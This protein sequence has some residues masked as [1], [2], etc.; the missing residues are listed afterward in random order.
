[1]GGKHEPRYL[2]C[3]GR[4]EVHANARS[5]CFVIRHSCFVIPLVTPTSPPAPLRLSSLDAYRGLVILT[6]TYVNYISGMKGIPAWAQHMPGDARDGYTFVDLVFPG[7]LFIVGVAIPLALHRRMSEGKSLWPLVCRILLRSASLIFVGVITV[8]GSA[9]NAEATGMSRALWFFLAMVCVMAVWNIYPANPSPRRKKLFFALRIVAGLELAILLFIFRGKNSDGQIVW[10][11]HSWWGILGLIGWAYLVA[12]FAYL[13][14]RGNSTGL[15]AVLGFL[16]ALYIGD[17]HGALDWL[18]PVHDFIGV[19]QV[20]GST[21]SSV[22]MGT[23]VGNCFVG[24]NAS[25]STFARARFMF[26]FGLGLYVAGELIRPVHGINKNAATDSYSLV[27]GGI[28]CLC[29]LL[30]YLL[31]DVAHLRRWA[32][33]FIPVGQNPL[34]AYLLPGMLGNFLKLIGAGA[35]LWPYSSNLPGALN[36]AAVTCL[37]LFLTWLATRVGIRLKL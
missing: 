5:S 22:V 25:L 11:Q 16:I 8:N 30:V 27:S 17:K 1:M 12:S 26:L 21:A 24:P 29:F 20:L 4:K 28:C 23:L 31:M 18:G 14:V 34:F 10:L 33:P 19:G 15:M 6:M 32:A 9:F 36:A 37:I 3:Y 13:A 2:G 35:L 7:F